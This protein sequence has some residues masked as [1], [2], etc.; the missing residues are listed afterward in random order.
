MNRKSVNFGDKK[1]KKSSFYKNEKIYKID[2]INFNKILVSKKKTIWQK[3]SIKYFIEYNKTT[4]IRPLCI[5]LPQ[6]IGYIKCFDSNKAMF[7]KVI[8]N[9]LLRKYTQICKKL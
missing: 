5:K 1:I 6:M 9:K 2:D 3:K 7:F 8:D 4:I